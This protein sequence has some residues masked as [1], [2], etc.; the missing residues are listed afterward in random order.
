[1][2]GG[3]RCAGTGATKCFQLPDRDKL[4]H[5]R[6][7]RLP[8]WLARWPAIPIPVFAVLLMAIVGGCYVNSLQVPFLLDDL[9]TIL[10][11]P[12]IRQLAP[13]RDVLFPPGEVYSAGRPVL[14]LS[15][16]INY[17][18]GGH[19]VGGYHAVNLAIHAAATL[20]LFAIVRRTL[21][22]PRCRPFL[23]GGSAGISFTIAALWAAHPLL[24]SAVTYVSQRAESLMGLFYLLT[25]YAFVRGAPR[26][27]PL[28]MAA[29]AS[30]CALGMAT[31][32]VMVTAPVL[33]F[34]FD[35]VFVAGSWRDAWAQRRT[36]HLLHAATW[37]LL[38]ALMIGSRLDQRAVGW[39]HGLSW[40]R[41]LC[42]ETQAVCLYV[43]RAFWPANLV[44][45]YG[46]NLPPPSLGALAGAAILLG[47]ALMLSIR[48]LWSGAIAGFLGTAFFL[49]LAPTS[50]IVPLAGQPI[51]ESRMYLPLA[52]LV[53]A[54][55][56]GVMRLLPRAAPLL[57]VLTLGAAATLSYQRNHVYHSPASIWA[58]TYVKRPLNDRAVVF[59]AEELKRRG[60]HGE[61][62]AILEARIKARPD[63]PEML[64]NLAVAL[65][66][67]GRAA[68]AL[69]RF[70]RAIELKPGNAE[71][72]GNCGTV[73]L[74]TRNFPAA[75]ESFENALRF[76]RE[77]AD[78]R[79]Y[80]GL[81][82]TGL[83]RP[84]EAMAQFERALQI[85]PSHREAQGNLAALRAVAK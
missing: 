3:K 42:I 75:L 17:A 15:F 56:L 71:L 6:A 39:E 45:D 19:S 16:A 70:R 27:S 14:N 7:V 79:N 4:G 63:S 85:D 74:H 41:Y 84:R 13:L 25:L 66:Q 11:N 34:L 30:A 36:W 78:I 46:S 9:T 18:I 76:G 51:A 20:A 37:L 21:A 35:R 58:D 55:V 82:L 68:E 28:W 1:M 24:T 47:A 8:P 10:A 52:V 73:L 65:F 67:A 50:S 57:A 59:W 54:V 72:H 77:T 5:F 33:V 26:R 53:A 62:L 2:P 32:E 49:L 38:A 60:Q 48:A 31:K 80:V 61:A 69:Q 64:N 43:A 44:F 40:F 81:C 29:G 23:S 12:S 22:L 83:G